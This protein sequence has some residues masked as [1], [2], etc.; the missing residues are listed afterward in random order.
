MI[1][2]VWVYCAR[3]RQYRVMSV[4]FDILWCLTDD[5]TAFPYADCGLL[6]GNFSDGN[7]NV[8]FDRCFARERMPNKYGNAFGFGNQRTP[9]FLTI[10]VVPWVHGQY[11]MKSFPI[12]CWVSLDKPGAVPLFPQGPSLILWGPR[13]FA[14]SNFRLV[15]GLFL[16]FIHWCSPV[17]VDSLVR[18]ILCAAMVRNRQPP[19]VAT[20]DYCRT[21]GFGSSRC[22]AYSAPPGIGGRYISLEHHFCK[23]KQENTTTTNWNMWN[24]QFPAQRPPPGHRFLLIIRL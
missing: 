19:E 3:H 6:T 17:T 4:D 11:V 18:A 15:L 13:C 16:T 22:K 20:G 9:P 1:A 21:R 8:A 5:P 2:Q 10:R 24:T 23:P 7:R 12:V 14:R